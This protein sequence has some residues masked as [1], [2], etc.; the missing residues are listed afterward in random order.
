MARTFNEEDYNQ[1]R[2][3]I[4]L[5][6]RKL[7]YTRGYEQMSI[8]DIINDLGISKGAYYHYFKSKPDLLEGLTNQM[9]ADA[10]KILAPIVDDPSMNGLEK[11]N[12]YFHRASAWKTEQIDYL[13]TIFRVW[14][15]DENVLVREKTLVATLRTILPGLTTIIQQ[16]VSEG[17]FKTEYPG[18]ISE[19]IYMLFYGMGSTLGRELIILNGQYFDEK[20]FF[21]TLSAYNR[22]LEMILGLPS[23]SLY[24]I[25]EEAIKK[26]VDRILNNPPPNQTDPIQQTMLAEA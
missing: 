8:Q 4:L 17:L 12:E 7:I 11:L 25:Q 2:S 13:L 5:S 18:E 21:N 26:W 22:S 23:G 1:K 14:Y 19:V 15:Q 3:D 20:K 10:L 24:L 6:A 16:G 9:M